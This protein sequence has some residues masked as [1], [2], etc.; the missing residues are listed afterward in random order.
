MSNRSAKVYNC[1]ILV[2]FCLVQFYPFRLI[3]L[4][5]I[6]YNLLHHS[7]IKNLYKLFRFISNYEGFYFYI[8]VDYI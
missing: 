1:E 6:Q 5:Y 8:N 4:C 2:C 7:K 3:D